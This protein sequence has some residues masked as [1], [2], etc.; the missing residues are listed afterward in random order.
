MSESKIGRLELL[1]QKCDTAVENAGLGK[2]KARVA[3]ALDISVSMRPLFNKGAV[4]RVCERLLALGMEFDD[5]ASVDVFLFGNHDY[6]VGELTEA[7]VEGFVE[8]DIL[9]KHRLEGKTNYAGVM[10]RIVKKYTSEYGKPAYVLF[11]A[12]GNNHDEAE[13]EEAIIEASE[14]PIFWQFVGIGQQKFEF[15]EKL[16]D[17]PNRQI[18]NADFFPLNDLDKISDEELYKKMLTEF[19]GWLEEA[20]R[21]KL[22]YKY[23]NVAFDNVT[24]R[25]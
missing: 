13:A 5:D 3:L 22:Y 25:L 1:K 8:Q 19:P 23:S 9:G 14:A 21:Q 15:L 6:E 7:N 20:K 17:I 4:Q 24:S 2:Q 16:D 12:D 10:R 11:L 18:D